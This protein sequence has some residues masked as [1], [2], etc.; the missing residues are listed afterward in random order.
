VGDL[1]PERLVSLKFLG[2]Q[3]FGASGTWTGLAPDDSPLALCDIGSREIYALDY[4]QT[5]RARE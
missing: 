5:I 4:R 3:A 1:K 2:T